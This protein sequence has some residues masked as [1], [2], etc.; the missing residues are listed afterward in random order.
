ME[1][2]YPSG[3]V[4]NLVI[5]QEN[6]KLHGRQGKQASGSYYGDFQPWLD[7]SISSYMDFRSQYVIKSNY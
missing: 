7:L 4:F 2:V 1:D 6:Q 5:F 3:E